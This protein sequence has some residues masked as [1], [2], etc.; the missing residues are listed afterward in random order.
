MRFINSLQ[1]E[2]LFSGL[3]AVVD[4]KGRRFLTQSTVP[5]VMAVAADGMADA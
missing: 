2:G 4:Y 1:L 3:T 5:G